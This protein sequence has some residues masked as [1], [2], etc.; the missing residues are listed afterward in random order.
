MPRLD[1]FKQAQDDSYAGFE[2]A[3]EEIQSGRKRGHW[4]WYVLPQLD[5]LGMSSMARAYA[6]NGEAEAV[7]YLRDRQ[8][9]GRLLTMT[10]A[11][12]EQLAAG[13]PAS[14]GQN[15]RLATLMGSEIDAKK[16]V[17]SLTLFAEVARRLAA[18]EDAASD[19]AKE[20]ASVADAARDV[21]TIAEAQGYPPCV[22]TRRV[23][24]MTN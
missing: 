12:A 23:L 3:L 21:L 2:T 20:Y 9:R 6:L 18:E 24:G 11:V 5:G 1:R 14:G 22:F 16:L 13:S 17:S 19:D 15:L 8:L 10:R 7:D 4:I